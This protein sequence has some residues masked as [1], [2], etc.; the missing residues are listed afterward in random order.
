MQKLYGQVIKELETRPELLTTIT[1]LSVLTPPAE[2]IQE[3]LSAV[4]LPTTANYMYGVSLPF[5]FH[6]V[7]ASPRFKEELLKPGTSEIQ[8]PDANSRQKLETEMKHFAYGLILKKYL[9]YNNPDSSRFIYSYPDNQSGLTH[10]MEMRMDGRFID[11]HPAGE[12]PPLP[13]PVLLISIPT[14]L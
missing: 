4:F 1:D 7:Y 12:M 3:L 13:P 9:G 14:V 11:V 2:L 6:S 10:Y 8:F 5:T